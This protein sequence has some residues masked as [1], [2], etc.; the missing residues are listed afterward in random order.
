MQ[1]GK[2]GVSRMRT[3]MSSRLRQPC[4]SNGGP[5]TMLQNNPAALA[6]SAQRIV[7]L[8]RPDRTLATAPE[9]KGAGQR[10]R[11]REQDRRREFRLQVETSQ[12]ELAQSGRGLC[13]EREL[14]L[15]RKAPARG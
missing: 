11:T 9:L 14:A 13:Q 8:V 6:S 15:F 12:R 1:F 4:V 2:T 3:I 10:D 7:D 5:A